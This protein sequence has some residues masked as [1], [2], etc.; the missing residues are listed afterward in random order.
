MQAWQWLILV[1]VVVILVP[2]IPRVL[3][4]IDAKRQ[5]RGDIPERKADE[6]FRPDTPHPGDGSTADGEIL[7]GQ[8]KMKSGQNVMGMK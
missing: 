8:A 4:A 3:A 5:L 1:L 6:N 7:A 2:V